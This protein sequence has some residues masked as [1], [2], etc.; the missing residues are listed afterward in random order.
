MS[1]PRR[2]LGLAWSP[3]SGFFGRISA[4]RIGLPWRSTIP[5]CH[6]PNCV[7]GLAIAFAA[8]RGSGALWFFA[9]TAH[10]SC[11]RPCCFSAWWRGGYP[12]LRCRIAIG[13]RKVAVMPRRSL[14][15]TACVSRGVRDFRVSPAATIS[16]CAIR[17]VKILLSHVTGLDFYVVLLHGR[18]GRTYL[19]ELLLRQTRRR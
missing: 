3:E 11:L 19:R 10:V 4:H 6:G 15:V 8:V 16:R 2:L 18:T 7:L 5:I 13:G 9:A 12:F 17:S 14:T 1:L